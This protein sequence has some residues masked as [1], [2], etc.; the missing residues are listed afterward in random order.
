MRINS[1]YDDRIYINDE[2]VEDV[3]KFVYLGATLTKSRGGMDDM[4][5]KFQRGEIHTGSSVK[6]GT[7]TKS[8]EQQNSS[9]TN[10]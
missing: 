8:R 4:E 7:V 3:D 5:N 2:E 1:R 6:Y 9:Y 10:L